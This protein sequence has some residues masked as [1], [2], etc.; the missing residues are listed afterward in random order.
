MAVAA[1]TCR[2]A[3]RASRSALLICFGGS[4]SPGAFVISCLWPI[5]ARL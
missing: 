1:S 3:L 2:K 5:D 4:I